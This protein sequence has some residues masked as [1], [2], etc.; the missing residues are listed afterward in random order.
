MQIE[1]FYINL[2]IG[3]AALLILYLSLYVQYNKEMTFSKKLTRIDLI[4]NGVLMATTTSILFALT[5]GGSKYTWSSWHIITPL[6][7]GFC[8]VA[9]FAAWEIWGFSPEPVVPPRLFKNRTSWVVAINTFLNCAILYWMVF[10]LPVYFQT[11]LLYSPARTGVALLPQSLVAIPGAA[12]SAIALSKW[13]KFKPLHWCGFGILTLGLGLFVLLDE[14]SSIARWVVFQCVA[15]LGAGMVLNTLLP[16]FQAPVEESD[17][18]AAT[19]VWC[20][21]RTFGNVWGVAIPAVIFNNRFDSMSYLI[22]DPD[23]RRLFSGG[24]AYQYASASF[25]TSFPDATAKEIRSVYQA[26]MQVVFQAAIAFSGLAF[27]LV[28]LEKEI[29]L[30]TELET[31]FGLK[32]ESSKQ[33]TDVETAKGV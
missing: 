28:F 25:I 22:T 11:V 7:V 16:S 27:L 33:L 6:V 14:N 31:E 4:G 26:A 19:A 1:A 18:A 10:F 5:Y 12:I 21:I 17:Q 8:G 9:L 29:P 2:P 23:A 13:G 32:K 20:F 15:A 30:R 24:H 3:G